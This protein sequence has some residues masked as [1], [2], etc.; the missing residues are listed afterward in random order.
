MFSQL[1]IV[2]AMMRGHRLRYG[3][4]LVCLVAATTLNY[5]V[6]LVGSAT[7]DYAI[8]GKTVDGTTPFLIAQLLRLVGGPAALH[9]HL[10]LATIAMVLLSAASGTFTYLKG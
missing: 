7:I 2:W 8:A 5:G 10:W 9:Q 6:P 4:A 1:P 3:L